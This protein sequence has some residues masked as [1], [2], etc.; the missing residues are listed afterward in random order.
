[1]YKKSV[2]V[3]NVITNL[4]PIHYIIEL[5]DIYTIFS[6]L[7]LLGGSDPSPMNIHK[8]RVKPEM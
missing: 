8:V 7:I 6:T 2:C 5:V 1:M 3:Y 4:K